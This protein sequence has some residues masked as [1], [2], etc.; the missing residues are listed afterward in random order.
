[1]DRPFRA[2][3]CPS[4]IGAID[5][6][7]PAFSMKLLANVHSFSMYVQHDD[8]KADDQEVYGESWSSA[9]S[10]KKKEDNHLGKT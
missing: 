9:T 4:S 7:V 6:I 2:C 3:R 5:A 1:V 8:N 10:P